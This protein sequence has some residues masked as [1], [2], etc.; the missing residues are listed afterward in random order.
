MSRWPSA[1][2]FEVLPA[3]PATARDGG[4][5]AIAGA[6]CGPKGSAGIVP[7]L[8]TPCL[9]LRHV[10]GLPSHRQRA[11]GREQGFPREQQNE[12]PFLAEPAFAALLAR[13][14]EALRAP[15]RLASGTADHRQE[16]HREG[17]RRAARPGPAH[18]ER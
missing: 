2:W 16:G 14:R 10:Q 9:G 6:I 4:S 1:A 8:S 18:L 3:L 5:A 15:A 12:A 7:A 13:E 11:D 17:R